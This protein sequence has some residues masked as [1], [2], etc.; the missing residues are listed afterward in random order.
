MHKRLLMLA[1]LFAA[2]LFLSCSSK[3]DVVI[4]EENP[5]IVPKENQNIDSEEMEVIL[6]DSENNLV[7]DNSV[8]YEELVKRHYEMQSDATKKMMKENAKR[9]KRDTPIRKKSFFDFNKKNSCRI[10][11][12]AVIKDGVRDTK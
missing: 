3:K 1:L 2:S 7:N 12:D 10:A 11:D 4:P 6:P 8:S 9:S 5:M